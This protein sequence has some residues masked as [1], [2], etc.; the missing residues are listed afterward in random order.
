[1]KQA[2]RATAQAERRAFLSMMSSLFA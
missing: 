2:S 1:M